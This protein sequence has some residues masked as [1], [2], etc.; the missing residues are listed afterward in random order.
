LNF[1]AGSFE[2]KEAKA[3]QIRVPESGFNRLFHSYLS[4]DR[5][6]RL[7]NPGPK[8]A[9]SSARPSKVVLTHAWRAR[10]HEP[11]QGV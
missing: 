9:Q 10:E 1:F 11:I 3:V 2:F 7:G 8:K 5:H 4:N 6:D